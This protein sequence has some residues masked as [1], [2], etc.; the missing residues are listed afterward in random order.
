MISFKE[1]Q[2]KIQHSLP[3]W[4][5]ADDYSHLSIDTSNTSNSQFAWEF[6][7]RNKGYQQDY[8]DSLT[9]ISLGDNPTFPLHKWGLREF[10]HN[11]DPSNIAHPEFY[12]DRYPIVKYNKKLKRKLLN[13]IEDHPHKDEKINKKIKRYQKRL[14]DPKKISLTMKFSVG[15]NIKRQLETAKELLEIHKQ[16]VNHIGTK[17]IDIGK[18]DIKYIKKSYAGY[19][20]AYDA[21]Y[22]NHTPLNKA[23]AIIREIDPNITLDDDIESAM[24]M[25]RDQANK[26]KNIVSSSYK[27]IVGI[28]TRSDV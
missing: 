19:L 8:F 22:Y 14:E 13:Y 4:E 1:Y 11:L 2:D 16:F 20:R 6:L 7:R 15:W 23:A 10:S 21:I 3:R 24:K 18:L 26:G 27:N 28:G 17:N 12:D 9:S 5:C 25:V